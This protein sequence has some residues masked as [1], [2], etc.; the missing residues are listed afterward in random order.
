[1][2]YN[3]AS[4]KWEGGED[5]DMSGFEESDGEEGETAFY[6]AIYPSEWTD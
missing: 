3:R 1:M 6:R 4:Q 2:Y 5:V